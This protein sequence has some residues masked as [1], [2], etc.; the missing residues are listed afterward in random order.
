M[1]STVIFAIDLYS[2]SVLDLE[3]MGCFRA[4]HDTKFAPRNTAIPLVDLLSSREAAQSASEKLLTIR[5]GDQTMRS[6]KTTVRR[7]YLKIIF[8]TTS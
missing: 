1:I 2:T 4:L 3:T 6:P 5:D 7:T 8:I